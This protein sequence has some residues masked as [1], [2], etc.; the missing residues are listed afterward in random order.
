MEFLECEDNTFLLNFYTKNKFKLFDVRTTIPV[1]GN[2][3][4]RLNQLLKFKIYI[5]KRLIINI[6]LIIKRFFHTYSTKP[7]YSYLKIKVQ[8]TCHTM[9]LTYQNQQIKQNYLNDGMTKKPM[10]KRASILYLFFDYWAAA[11]S[12]KYV[13]FT[14]INEL[15]IRL[16]LSDT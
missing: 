1:H 14:S 9:I 7:E 5:V 13:W 11:A 3:P 10:A 2:E 4:H 8:I 15:M 12:G 6:V 16:P